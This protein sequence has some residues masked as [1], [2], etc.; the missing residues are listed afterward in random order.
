[1]VP[2]VGLLLVLGLLVFLASCTIERVVLY[3]TIQ[4]P[5]PVCPSLTEGVRPSARTP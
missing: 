2:V 4:A 1:V 5:L 3:E